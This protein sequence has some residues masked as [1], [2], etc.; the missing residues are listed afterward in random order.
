M[1]QIKKKRATVTRSE[2]TKK[3]IAVTRQEQSD[4]NCFSVELDS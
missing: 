1:F 2:K 3:Q 4:E